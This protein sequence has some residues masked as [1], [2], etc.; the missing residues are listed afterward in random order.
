MQALSQEPYFQTPIPIPLWI[1]SLLMAGVRGLS[2]NMNQHTNPVALCATRWEGGGV[3]LS[4]TKIACRGGGVTKCATQSVRLTT[5]I[6]KSHVSRQICFAGLV[7][8]LA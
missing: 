5:L 8:K 4:F 2:L 7:L 1:V 3:P 6:A